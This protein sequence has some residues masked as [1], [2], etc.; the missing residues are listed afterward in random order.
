[1]ERHGVA[2][3]HPA[4]EGQRASDVTD[5]RAF[6]LDDPRSEV[7]QPHRGNGCQRNWLKSRT[8]S[9]SKGLMFLS[10]IG[11]ASLSGGREKSV[12]NRLLMVGQAGL[13]RKDDG[14]ARIVH[15][16]G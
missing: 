6:D 5:P 7:S 9:P 1:M 12:I 15:N 8:S 16:G 10:V 13:H 4:R 2:V 11:C 14:T 3:E